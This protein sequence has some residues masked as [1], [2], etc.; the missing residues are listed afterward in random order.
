MLMDPPL[1]LLPPSIS[2]PTNP[3]AASALTA[4][5][6]SR[7]SS[8]AAPWRTT[9]LPRLNVACRQ[10]Q[11][12]HRRRTP[13]CRKTETRIYLSAAALVLLIALGMCS[14]LN[15]RT[16]EAL[17]QDKQQAQIIDDAIAERDY[18]AGKYDAL[19]HEADWL[20]VSEAERKF[21]EGGQ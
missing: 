14:Y 10:K 1:Q 15:G 9:S 13:M 7:T 16:D 19:V 20:T 12:A 5:P 3:S 18:W 17:R 21:Q 2:S 8:Q 4:K 11:T 6:S